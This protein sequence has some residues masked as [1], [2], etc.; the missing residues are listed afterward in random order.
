MLQIVRMRLEEA[1]ERLKKRSIHLLCDME[2]LSGH[3]AEKLRALQFGAR[4]IERLIEHTVLA[5][6]SLATLRVNDEGEI[7]AVIGEAFYEKGQVE[8]MGKKDRG[9]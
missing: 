8:V 7:E 6:I 2:R 4:G 9:L 5:P 3:L 1:M